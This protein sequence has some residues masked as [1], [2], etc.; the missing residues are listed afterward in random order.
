MQNF[1]KIEFVVAEKNRR[2]INADLLPKLSI[3]RHV[4]N[5]LVYLANVII[6]FYI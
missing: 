3:G 1:I 4:K 5:S 6:D 2:I